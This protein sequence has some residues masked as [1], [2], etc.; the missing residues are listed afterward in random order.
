[1]EGHQICGRLD[2]RDG[3][4][5]YPFAG[6]LNDGG[7]RESDFT[8]GAVDRG[9]D[10]GNFFAGLL[11]GLAVYSRSLSPAEMLRLARLRRPHQANL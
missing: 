2:E 8:V 10:I 11:G 1:M 7:P 6:G 3:L 9:G 4:S 5:P